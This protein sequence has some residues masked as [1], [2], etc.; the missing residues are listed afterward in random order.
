[1]T[2]WWKCPKCSASNTFANTKCFRCKRP[3]KL[4]LGRPGAEGTKHGHK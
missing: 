4:S 2:Q 1:M 3:R